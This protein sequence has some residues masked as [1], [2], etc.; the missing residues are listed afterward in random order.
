[1]YNIRHVLNFYSVHHVTDINIPMKIP[2][3]EIKQIKQYAVEFRL[4]FQNLQ[5]EYKTL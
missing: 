3:R 2:Y 4:S 5:S 1:M